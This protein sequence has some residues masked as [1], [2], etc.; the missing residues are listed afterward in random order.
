[1]WQMAIETIVIGTPYAGYCR[2]LKRTPLRSATPTAV[3]FA[4]ALVGTEGKREPRGHAGRAAA[5][6]RADDEGNSN[7]CA[8]SFFK[9]GS[10]QPRTCDRELAMDVGH[11]IVSPTAALN[12]TSGDARRT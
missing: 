1:M 4:A 3:K 10:G 2:N 8:P 6:N 11:S 5:D 12:T 7:R 9:H